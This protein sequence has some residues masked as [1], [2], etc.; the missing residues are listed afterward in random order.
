MKK[1]CARCGKKFEA[2]N[3]HCWYCEGC[4]EVHKKE[5]FR[6]Y[7]EENRETINSYNAWWMREKRK[8]EWEEIVSELLK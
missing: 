3:G 8:R 7:R 6:Q 4:K 1:R 5:Y 2:R